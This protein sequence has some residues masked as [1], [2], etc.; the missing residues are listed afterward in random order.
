M[1]ETLQLFTDALA[2][3]IV[4]IATTMRHSGPRARLTP[5]TQDQEYLGD[6][7]A[8]AILSRLAQAPEL[9]VIAR[10]S[11]FSFKDRPADVATIAARR[12]ASLVGQRRALPAGNRVA[13]P[14]G[15]GPARA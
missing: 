9:K 14:H 15:S 5:G 8:E 12:R 3:A 1:F 2:I 13:A 10:T 4:F 11:S 7:I 6:G